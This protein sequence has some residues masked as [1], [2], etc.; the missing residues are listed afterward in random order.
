MSPSWTTT[1]GENPYLLRSSLIGSDV[2]HIRAVQGDKVSSAALQ[3]EEGAS[4]AY[5]G[6]EDVLAGF[7]DEIPLTIYSL[8]PQRQPLAINASNNFI[9]EPVNLGLRVTG[10]G[11]IKL[12]FSGL[13]TFRHKVFLVDKQLNKEIDLQQTPEHSFTVAVNGATEVNDR[14]ALR[15]TTN[16]TGSEPIETPSWRVY[17]KDSYIYVQSE[18]EPIESLQIYNTLGSLIYSASSVNERQH[19]VAVNGGQQIYL[20][21]AR[22][23]NE[24]KTEKVIVK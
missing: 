19:K 11:E 10:S 1:V 9:S 17:S 4:S 7:F 5:L 23:G 13:S 14:F 18:G 15:M 3:Y 20:V 21:K 24:H 16:I 22:I 12:E 6:S 8:S 2:L